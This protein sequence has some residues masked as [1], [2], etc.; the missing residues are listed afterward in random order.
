M[1][2]SDPDDDMS[3][4]AVALRAL[5]EIE[6][7][8]AT[9][10]LS[11]TDYDAAESQV[12]SGSASCDATAESAESGVGSPAEPTALSPGSRLLS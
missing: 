6:F 12:H 2:A 5:K 8:R 4:Q 9:G 1:K 7:D 3:P 10:K 11:D